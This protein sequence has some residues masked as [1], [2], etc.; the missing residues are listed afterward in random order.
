MI[1]HDQQTARLASSR[2]LFTRRPWGIGELLLAKAVTL[3][4]L[5]SIGLACTA[6]PTPSPTP[7]EETEPLTVEQILSRASEQ[8]GALTSFHFKMTHDGGGTPIALGL[9]MQVAEGKVVAPDRMSVTIKAK[10]RGL[11]LE[12]SAINVGDSTYMTNPFTG[13]YEDFTGVISPGSFF[14]P[15]EGV[16]AIIRGATNP[17]R[18]ADETLSG[19]PAYHL[20][21]SVASGELKAIS[22]E[23][24]EGHVIATE[25][26]IGKEDFLIRRLTLKGRITE[27]KQEG[28]TRTIVVSAFDQPVAIEA[29]DLTGG[30]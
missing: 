10:G 3:A 16:G 28:I 4:L 23:A 12:V 17:S 8:F 29:P 19:V 2:R 14:D 5:L 20:A 24:I 9:E 13:R 22:V 1:M 7:T 30:S 11:H 6:N 21:G 25:I 26:W 15:A 18:L 27:D